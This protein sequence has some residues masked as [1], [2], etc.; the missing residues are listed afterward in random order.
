MSHW[1]RRV[2]IWRQP[3]KKF[4]GRWGIGQSNIH[5]SLVVT[6]AVLAAALLFLSYARPGLAEFRTTALTLPIVWVVSLI[7]RIAAQQLAIGDFSHDSD[8]TVCPT[9][10][11]Q[12][13]YEY[14]PPRAVLAY[15]VSGQL[16]S[17]GM[18]SIGLVVNAA[19]TPAD[20][21]Q[22]TIAEL[23]GFSGGWHSQAWA[24]QIFWVNVFLFGL[25][26]LPTVPF[27]M[28]ALVFSCFSWKSR[29]AQEP[30]V[31][32]R[33]AAFNSHLS[34]VVFGIGLTLVGLGFVFGHEAIGWYALIGAIYLFVASQWEHSRA[35]ELEDQFMQT[36]RVKASTPVAAL[37][38]PHLEFGLRSDDEELDPVDLIA[39]SDARSD[40]EDFDEDFDFGNAEES[41]NEHAAY[42]EDDDTLPPF[43]DDEP[44]DVDEI[45]RKVHKDGFDSLNDDERQAL[46]SASKEFQ[47]KRGSA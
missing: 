32:R 21:G 37:M 43:D 2:Q 10:N 3:R 19:M 24:T 46:I 27:D 20:Y 12:T 38:K 42:S 22:I 31:F 9:G 15:A 41:A 18:M 26:L 40:F 6:L 39:G 28:R 5:S 14:L 45:L 17:I 33:I 44:V 30:H 23:L 4:G 16:A 36:P 11:L 35:D 25:H 34:A 29:T 13:D 8:T 7:V 1:F 47:E